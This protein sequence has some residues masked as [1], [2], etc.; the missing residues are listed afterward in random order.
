MIE[1]HTL[2]QI[3][4]PIPLFSLD[5]HK[6]TIPKRLD[7]DH[8]TVHDFAVIIFGKNKI[9]NL[10]HSAPNLSRLLECTRLDHPHLLG[11]LGVHEPDSIFAGLE[12]SDQL[13]RPA[14]RIVLLT[15][16]LERLTLPNQNQRFHFHIPFVSMILQYMIGNA[17]FEN[18]E[19]LY[20]TIL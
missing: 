16:N 20:L 19:N 7:L 3:D 10:D 17:S 14:V 2:V 9:T 5:S 15:I 4:R 18:E 1:R 11:I 13:T 12:R 6:D 8:F